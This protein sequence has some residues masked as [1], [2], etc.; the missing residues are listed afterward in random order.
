MAVTEEYSLNFIG[1]DCFYEMFLIAFKKGLLQKL[2]PF[3]LSFFIE[4]FIKS[5]IPVVPNYFFVRRKVMN[6]T[7]SMTLRRADKTEFYR[8]L[9]NSR[10]TAL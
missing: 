1:N 2:C 4:C 8:Q 6:M 7:L 10:V 9:G 5:D 3:Q